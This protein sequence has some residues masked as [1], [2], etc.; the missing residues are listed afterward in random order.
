[1]SVRY[2]NAIHWT[3]R[4]RSIETIDYAPLPYGTFS[5]RVIRISYDDTFA[6]P[7]CPTRPAPYGRFDT[8]EPSSD[9]AAPLCPRTVFLWTSARVSLK[10]G[11]RGS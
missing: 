10:L 11:G 4:S 6:G 9:I 3:F 7:S 1:M 5:P 2:A 8:D